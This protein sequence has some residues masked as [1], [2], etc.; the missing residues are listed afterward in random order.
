MPAIADFLKWKKD[1]C[2]RFCIER[3]RRLTNCEGLE[4]N[5]S[6]RPGFQGVGYSPGIL[7]TV[8]ETSFRVFWQAW[9]KRGSVSPEHNAALLLLFLWPLNRIFDERERFSDK[10][11]VFLTYEFD[12]LTRF[13]DPLN[14][15]MRS[16]YSI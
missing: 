13:F 3:P 15:N 9:Q 12:Q 8:I 5:K 1:F 16:A 6:L 7:S 14:G 10:F 2:P 11:N 4:C